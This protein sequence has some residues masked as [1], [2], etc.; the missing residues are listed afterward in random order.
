M[1]ATKTVEIGSQILN[2]MFFEK[3]TSDF[4]QWFGIENGESHQDYLLT[5][6]GKPAIRDA[7]IEGIDLA[8]NKVFFCSFLFADT[9]IVEALCR[10][11]ERL[12]GG[13][14]VLTSLAREFQP[15]LT[16][17]G[18]DLDSRTRLAQERRNIHQNNLEKLSSA[19]VWLRTVDDCHAKFCVIDDHWA[20]LTSAN[21]TRE[22]YERNPENGVIIR[23]PAVAKE[24]G[25]IFAHVFRF[26][27]S[28]ESSPGQRL[29]VRTMKSVRTE[30]WNELQGNGSLRP[31]T[32]L[33]L[34]EQSLL[35]ETIKLFNEAT[36]ELCIATY[37]FVGLE[38]HPV[39]LA[40]KESLKRGVKLVLA[41]R[42]RN[43]N[44]DQR[45]SLAWL[46][47]GI[48]R[49]QWVMRG[50]PFT[51]AKAIV[52][53]GSKALLWTG[54]LD[55]HHGYDNGIELGAIIEDPS[56]VATIRHEII[57]L[58]QRSSFIPRLNPTLSEIA[59]SG[60]LPPLSGNWTLNIPSG[61]K[62]FLP[63]D[64]AMR[65]S[66]D[67]VGYIKERKN[68]FLRIGSDICLEIRIEEDSRTM[69]VTYVPR[70]SS[71]QPLSGFISDCRMTI[72]E[73]AQA[74]KENQKSSNK[75]RRDKNRK[76]KRQ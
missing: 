44:A 19:G 9:T 42:P 73:L 25:R 37:S 12:H 41:L 40:L 14:Y 57:R 72:Q 22:A 26:Y 4:P 38:G 31:V 23:N 65:L 30:K 66:T 2:E 28:L 56:L 13:V 33:R 75:K 48:P 74:N 76:R 54:N 61:L 49:Q 27:G 24:M 50:H 68:T 16:D 64:L 29:D 1:I 55:G 39:G 59:S 3:G 7:L 34:R 47:E 45:R 63:Q 71:F 53:D 6:L 20:L 51:H 17:M 18:E 58:A 60:R 8:T 32:T 69:Q 52:A 70:N 46:L 35:N 62:R 10:A 36:A 43:F 15:D 11:S 67:I 5:E 21:A